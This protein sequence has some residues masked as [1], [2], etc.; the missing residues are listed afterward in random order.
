MIRNW[1]FYFGFLIQHMS[2]AIHHLNSLIYTMGFDG[3]HQDNWWWY[4]HTDLYFTTW[5]VNP[6][7]AFGATSQ[8]NKNKA[9]FPRRESQANSLGKILFK[10][11]FLIFWMTTL[12]PSWALCET[13][14]AIVLQWISFGSEGSV[15]TRHLSLKSFARL[16]HRRV[17]RWTLK[18]TDGNLKKK[19]FSD[20]LK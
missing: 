18:N 5:D 19:L 10:Y 7:W 4:S 14:L 3:F 9:W 1:Y 16:W 20:Y 17:S 8:W 6:Y 13:Q 11:A 12:N 2:F 15:T